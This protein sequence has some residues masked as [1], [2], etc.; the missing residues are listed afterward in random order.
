MNKLFQTAITRSIFF[1]KQS[2]F[3]TVPDQFSVV[4]K[5][6]GDNTNYPQKGDKVSVHYVGTF[7]D[8]KKFD[9]SRD[10]NQ[11][12]QFILG[13]GQVIRGWDEGVGKLSLG[14]VA[15]ITCPYQYAYGE[16]GYPGVI[17]PKATLL[18]EVELLSFKK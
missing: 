8:G 2:R 13:A 5:K 6:A 17:P 11:P 14:E 15:T 18:F 16:R 7:T 1:A 3:S 12:F 4:T 10:R 9:S